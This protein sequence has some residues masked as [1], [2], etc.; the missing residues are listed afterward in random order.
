MF[1]SVVFMRGALDH[2]DTAA[3]ALAAVD[4]SSLSDLALASHLLGVQH[5]L[6]QVTIHQARALAVAEQRRVWSGTG[7]RNLAE[8]LSGETKCDPN[9]VKDKA[10]L[11]EALG[12]SPELDDAV[13]NGDISP[14]AAAELAD[15]INDPPSG[16]D[17]GSLVDA[18]KGTTPK[19]AKKAA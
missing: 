12:N 7:A 11:G 9:D 19:E 18:A 8:W 13:K 3:R 14:D 15:T 10:K 16:A 2:C 17:P 5:H 6:D 4:V 1:A